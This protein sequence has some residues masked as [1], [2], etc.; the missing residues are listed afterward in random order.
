[1]QRTDCYTLKTANIVGMMTTGAVNYQHIATLQSIVVEEA[2]EVL[3]S[4][5]VAG[6]TA[7]TQHLVNS[8]W[9]SQTA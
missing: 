4:H 5:I 2:A 9:R 1:M 6:L 3:D 8:H 7:G